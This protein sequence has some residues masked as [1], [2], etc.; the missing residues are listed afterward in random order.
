[1]L[2]TPGAE[3][4]VPRQLTPSLAP[5][6]LHFFDAN[7]QA[8][9]AQDSMEVDLPMNCPQKLDDESLVTTFGHDAK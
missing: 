6:A 2:L 1:M 5:G 3:I 9:V 7:E 8:L 4:E